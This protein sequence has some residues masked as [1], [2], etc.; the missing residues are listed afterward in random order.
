MPQM[1]STSTMPGLELH[2]PVLSKLWYLCSA[3]SP[4]QLL[5]AEPH[6]V[7]LCTHRAHSPAF[8]GQ[9]IKR[10][11][12]V[13]FCLLPPT[14]VLLLYP[15]LQIPAAS[16]AP[17]TD[18]C[19]F[20]SGRPLLCL[21]STAVGKLSPGRKP[22]QT[23][24]SSCLFLFSQGSQSVLPVLQSLKAITSDFVQAYSCLELKD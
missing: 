14:V 19:L 12:H 10:N 5:S 9:R 15:D 4:E 3:L 8:F 2:V 22:G 6:R 18:F 17:N 24:G 16:A 21:G 7:S 1:F 13:D 11:S 20:S 23:W